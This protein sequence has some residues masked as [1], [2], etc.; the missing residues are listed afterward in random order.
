M[1]VE[2]NLISVQLNIYGW[3]YHTV[4]NKCFCSWQEKVV[5]V[6]NKSANILSC[7]SYYFVKIA[8]HPI[9]DDNGK[10]FPKLY[11]INVSFM[12]TLNDFFSPTFCYIVSC[13]SFIVPYDLGHVNL[14]YCL[15]TVL[16][17]HTV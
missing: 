16:Q 2:T 14:K 9:Y 7:Y 5:L 13:I 4:K 15:N 8:L 12:N 3:L 10:S 6:Y 17:T 1:F 11:T